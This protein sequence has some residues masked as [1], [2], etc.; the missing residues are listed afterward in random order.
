MQKPLGGERTYMKKL[1]FTLTEV[2]ITLVI[3]GFIAT[4]TLPSLNSN[5]EKKQLE[6]AT[7]DAYN[8]VQKAVDKYKID[9]EVYNGFA[10]SH[11]LIEDKFVENYFKVKQICTNPYECFGPVY[12]YLNS[13][14]YRLYLDNDLESPA[15]ILNNGMSIICRGFNTFYVDVNGPKKPN[16]LNKDLWI[17]QTRDDG[18]VADG[19]LSTE[20]P[21]TKSNIE[22][23]F[24]KC[25][26]SQSE[27]GC[28][29]HF[30][31][32]GHKFDY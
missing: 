4:I 15:Y 31:V 29:A 20:R 6:T 18:T 25:K 3:L 19:S 1:A 22:E 21:P 12:A 8:M 24:E 7:L 5:I 26:K 13:T 9:E 32:N 2:L 14:E 27:Y 30:L 28:F 17:W 23:D 10:D 16:V 11:M